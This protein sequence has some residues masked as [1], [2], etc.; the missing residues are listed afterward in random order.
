MHWS[1]RGL[2]PLGNSMAE[3]MSAHSFPT[4]A[5]A[6]VGMAGRFPGAHGLDDFWCK[7]RDGVESLETFSDADLE[8]AGVAEHSRSN[9]NYVRKGTVLEGADQFDASF[10]G[11]SPREAQIIDPQHRIFLE[12]A[13]EALEHAGLRAGRYWTEAS[14]RICRRKHKYLS[15]HADPAQS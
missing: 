15:A 12:C 8:R 6:I 2:A 13:W 9:R 4:H 1:E 10:F 11:Y 3:Q 14:R 7:I 5:I